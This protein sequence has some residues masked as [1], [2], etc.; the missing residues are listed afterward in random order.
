MNLHRLDP[1]AFRWSWATLGSIGL[2]GAVVGAVMLDAMMRPAPQAPP[3][4]AMVIEVSIVPSSPPVPPRETPPGPEQQETKPT[5]PVREPLRI[6]PIPATQMNIKPEVVVPVRMEQ[7]EDKPREE[8]RVEMT[9]A[10][11]SVPSP[12]AA[13]A[14]APT[15][16]RTTAAPSSAEQAWEGLVLSALER[17]KR[18]PAEAQRASQQDTVY[19]RLTLDRRGN[20]TNARIRRSRGYDLLDAEVLSLVRRASPLPAPPAEVTGEQIELTVPV[21]FFLRRGRRR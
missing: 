14:A 8:R 13:E 16:G 9:T 20:V 2:H 12:P 19:V 1:E 4:A 17:N 6:P 11:A 18:Y 21:E 5:P 7:I 15:V 10:P 3:P